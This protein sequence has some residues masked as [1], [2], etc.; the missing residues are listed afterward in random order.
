M[1]SSMSSLDDET[2]C[3][4]C[5]RGLFISQRE[6]SKEPVTDDVRKRLVRQ[7]T[8]HSDTDATKRVGLASLILR[9]DHSRPLDQHYDA[10]KV[11]GQG[12]QGSVTIRRKK[13][14][15]KEFAV[16]FIAK[17]KL[18]QDPCYAEALRKELEV[19]ILLD[20]PHIVRF[21]E[22]FE[23]ELEGVHLVMELCPGGTLEE[24]LA[25]DPSPSLE[26]MRQRFLELTQAVS[27]CHG[28]GVVHRDLKLENVLLNE[29]NTVKLCDFGLS[30]IRGP[31]ESGSGSRSR[32]GSG[33]ARG[34]GSGWLEDRCGSALYIAPEIIKSNSSQKSAKYDEKCDIW[35]MG[36]I[37]FSMLTAHY[38]GQI[39]HPFEPL[40]GEKNVY[41]FEPALLRRVLQKN[42][43][44]EFVKNASQEEAS[45]LHSLLQKD[46]K[47]RVSAVDVLDSSWMQQSQVEDYPD[48]DKLR[49]SLTKSFRHMPSF[50]KL[51]RFE[52]AVLVV[53]A[54]HAHSPALSLLKNTFHKMDMTGLITPDVLKTKMKKCG[55]ELED[56]VF[57]D[58]FE[59][60]NADGNGKITYT[61]WLAATLRKDLIESEA[62]IDDAFQFFDLDGSRSIELW[63]LE[64]FVGAEEAASV[65]RE[66]DSSGEGKISREDLGVFM[67]KLARSRK[68]GEWK[69]TG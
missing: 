39:V 3:C 11:I 12:A 17:D 9:R 65:L 2:G 15:G 54:H 24:Y 52:K 32:S 38:H 69:K 4:V 7:H 47:T 20:H 33:S 63:E 45:L 8:F 14:T 56:K 48:P 41:G 23:D 1:N 51:S 5:L 19:L 16:K 36:I 43:H 29:C 49:R 21:H 13:E 34:S 53:V 61:E 68:L 31:G 62:M 37:L 10:G 27:Y 59:A 35:A 66:V 55:V 40:E 28:R 42:P 67:R 58:L 6:Q 26:V 50:V 46:P 64:E 25:T 18:S 57:T 22:W 44:V 60:I 30:A